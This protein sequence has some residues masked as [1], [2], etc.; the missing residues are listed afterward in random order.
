M[1]SLSVRHLDTRCR[2]VRVRVKDKDWVR[3]RLRVRVRPPLWHSKQ[4][5]ISASVRLHFTSGVA[6]PLALT[7]FLFLTLSLIL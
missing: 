6:S 2:L 3:D 5:R 4:V 7:L 1:L